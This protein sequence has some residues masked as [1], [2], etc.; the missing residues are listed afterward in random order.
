M[1][2]VTLLNS[3]SLASDVLKTDLMITNMSVTDMLPTDI[4]S[5]AFVPR[6]P[7]DGFTV[8]VST[9]NRCKSVSY[10]QL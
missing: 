3:R 6:T 10:T 5:Q 1:E 7:S 9:E 8:R 2:L 4:T